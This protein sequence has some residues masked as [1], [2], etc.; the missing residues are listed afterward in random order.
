MPLKGPVPILYVTDIEKTIRFY[1]DV[2]GFRCVNHFQGW[3]SLQ[4]DAAEVMLSLPNEHLPFEKSLFTGSFYFHADDVDALWA[5]LREKTEVVYPIE[6]FDY[7]M[8]EFAIRDVNGYVL[9]FGQE[10]Q[11]P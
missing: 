11:S 1:C 10:I 8:R 5:Q 9:Q 3:A 6:S 4:R 7:G 2:L